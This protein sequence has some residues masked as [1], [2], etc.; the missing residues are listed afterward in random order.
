[1]AG[2]GH[3]EGPVR[4][5]SSAT[6]VVL[7]RSGS[8]ARRVRPPALH[9]TFTVRPD[10]LRNGAKGLEGGDHH[11]EDRLRVLEAERQDEGRIRVGP[12]GD[13]E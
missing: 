6:A 11:F 8:P 4:S 1:M 3:F 13:Q 5:G 12:S 2:G 10:F 7:E 9:R